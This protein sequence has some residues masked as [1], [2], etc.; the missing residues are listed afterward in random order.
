MLSKADGISAQLKPHQ[1][2]PSASRVAENRQNHEFQTEHGLNGQ[3]VQLRGHQASFQMM[4]VEVAL[5]LPRWVTAWLFWSK[6]RIVILVHPTSGRFYRRYQM[7]RR[8]G[9]A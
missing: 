4:I 9:C 7:R 6:R 8:Q 2:P 1:Q 5:N 3:N